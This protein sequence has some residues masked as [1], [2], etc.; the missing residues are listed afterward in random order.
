MEHRPT[1]TERRMRRLSGGRR[2]ALKARGRRWLA[3]LGAVV[4][5]LG[6]WTAYDLRAARR[7]LLESRSQLSAAAANLSGATDKDAD[8]ALRKATQSALA[9]TR[10]ADTRV[11]R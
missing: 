9:R 3:A 7:D 11:R 10:H 4:V 5:A 1:A 6:L 2:F 8:D